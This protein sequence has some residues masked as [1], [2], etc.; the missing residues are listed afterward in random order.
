M[1]KI[2]NSAIA[3]CR[4][5]LRR[6]FTLQ[7]SVVSIVLALFPPVMLGMLIFGTQVA[8]QKVDDQE[9]QQVMGTIQG[10]STF[11]IIFLVSLVCL[12]SL[13]LWAT[14]NVYSELEGKSWQFIAS[15]PGGRVSILLG[16]FLAS[17]LVSLAISTFAISL[18][19]LISDRM[20][21]I[22]HP[23]R[24]WISLFAI[25]FLGCLVY[26]AVFSLIGTLFNKRAMVVAAGYLVG[27][28]LIMASVPGALVN[29]LTIRFHLQELGIEWIG[30]F[31]PG[32][33]GSEFE[34][35]FAYGP[36]W[37]TWVH[38]TI[39][40]GVTAGALGAGLWVIVNREYITSEES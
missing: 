31:L 32:Q 21:S 10:F 12:L 2:L 4:F 22:L 14:S 30:W 9:V 1:N 29:K 39:L 3:T 7:R 8:Q 5:E 16:K 18:C 27:S 28:D 34:Y 13:L 24:L 6:S 36:A 20:L 26:S 38:V 19:V 33:A 35:R 15:R 11:A 23:E 37:P 17:F 40:L 25:Y